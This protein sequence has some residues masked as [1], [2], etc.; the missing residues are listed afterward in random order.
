MATLYVK[1]ASTMQIIRI[2]EQF[3]SLVWTERY[4]SYGDFEL[5]IPLSVANFDVYKYGNYL[6]FDE[7]QETMLIENIEVDDSI[8]D[9]MLKI[10]GRS[11]T[12]ILDR[13][14]NASRM[15]ELG[16]GTINYK[17]NFLHIQ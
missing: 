3:L 2:E 4:Q 12:C 17:G 9:P 6:Q 13:R 16:F 8:E 5:D 1:D 14:V 7:S 15:I 10:T 11:L